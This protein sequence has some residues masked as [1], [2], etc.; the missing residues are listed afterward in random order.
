MGDEKK[1]RVNYWNVA[2]FYGLVCATLPI[3]ATEIIWDEIA[4]RISDPGLTRSIVEA[5]FRAALLE[6]SFKF[7]GFFLAH[8]KCRLMTEREYMLAAGTIGLVYAIVEK[9]VTMNPINIILG[10]VFPMHVL[11]QANQGRHFY[12]YRDALEKGEKKRA[13]RELF[14]STGCILLLH[15]CWDAVI[16]LIVFFMDKNEFRAELTAG[17]LFVVLI[18]FAVTYMIISIKRSVRVLRKANREG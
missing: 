17:I 5:F 2:L 11:W 4:N 12:A 3:I 18:S 15:G 13:I 8:K 9:V 1:S 10:I 6:E 7:L 16:E 14:F